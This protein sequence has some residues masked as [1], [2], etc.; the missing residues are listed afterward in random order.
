MRTNGRFGRRNGY[1]ASLCLLPWREKML[2]A[3]RSDPARKRAAAPAI[4]ILVVLVLSLSA[5]GGGD[6]G[7]GEGTGGTN[8]GGETTETAA[9]VGRYVLPGEAV[10]PEGIA[11]DPKTGDFYVGSTTD[12]TIFKQNA[13]LD[14]GEAEVL[15][16]PGGDGRD[17]AVGTKVDDRQRLFI[18]GGDTGPSWSTMSSRVP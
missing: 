6:T 14:E 2:T 11:Y 8:G 3:L 13:G 9:S 10:Y 15:L 17:T 1:R 12:G 18:A 5:C 7:D 4:V 16:E